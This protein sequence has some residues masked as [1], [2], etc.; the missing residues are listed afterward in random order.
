MDYQ[1]DPNCSKILDQEQR[2]QCINF[3]KWCSTNSGALWEDFTNIPEMV[4]HDYNHSSRMERLAVLWCGCLK[5]NLKRSTFCKSKMTFSCLL[6]AIWLHDIGMKQ[7]AHLVRDP[8]QL[9]KTNISKV[10]QKRELHWYLGAERIDEFKD[11]LDNLGVQDDEL[12]VI[13]TLVKYHSKKAPLVASKA[14]KTIGKVQPLSKSKEGP[15]LRIKYPYFTIT[16]LI[17]CLDAIDIG[18]DR[19]GKNPVKR[20]KDISE[21][22]NNL[23]LSQ[24]ARNRYKRQ[25]FHYIKH[26]FLLDINFEGLKKNNG[27]GCLVRYFP[28]LLGPAFLVIYAFEAANHD[29]QEELKELNKGTVLKYISKELNQNIDCIKVRAYLEGYG[30]NFLDR[31]AIQKFEHAVK[32]DYEFKTS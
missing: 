14:F 19:C 28:D 5:D 4:H 16:T 23:S 29:I 32:E 20:F 1:T 26:G 27:L 31:N 21:I 9:S 13:K 18:V 17:R 22:I 11:D 12:S 8:K 30:I 3:R 7:Y 15:L 24:Q 25:I 6:L 2:D 10:E